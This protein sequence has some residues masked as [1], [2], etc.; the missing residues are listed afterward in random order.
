MIFEIIADR[1]NK[2]FRLILFLGLLFLIGFLA[3][4]LYIKAYHVSYLMSPDGLLYSNIAENFLQGQGL[5]NT[6]RADRVYVVGPVYPLILASVYKIFGLSNYAAVVMAQAILGAIS[7]VLAFK[8]GALLFGRSYGWVSFAL[9]LLYPLFPF[10][11]MY[12]LTE[13]TYV[14]FVTLFIYLMAFYSVGCLN[15]GQRTKSA[16]AIG[17]V[18]GIANLVRPLLMTVFPVILFWFWFIAGYKFKSAIKDFF[19][20]FF[21]CILVMSPWWIRNYYNYEKF[22]P[23]TNYGAFEFYAGNN[24]Y[25][26]TNEY[27]NSY[28]ITYDPKIKSMVEK[29]PVFRREEEY[30]RLAKTYILRYPL[31]FIQRTF[32]K[33]INLFWRP[34]SGWE[35]SYYKMPGYSLDRW[36]LLMGLAGGIISLIKF[37]KYGFLLLIAVYYGSVVSILTVV[38]AARYRI[39]IMPA[40]I[41]LA[42]LAIMEA[43]KKPIAMVLNPNF[44]IKKRYFANK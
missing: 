23:V 36:F 35:G 38:D 24:P 37:R 6:V 42:T 44:F 31:Q 33:E 5:N 12:V 32:Q 26:V 18:L 9:T 20:V 14:F 25:T 34:V 2:R 7:A 1:L 19:I 41:L 16:I 22:I 43:I 3:R 28:L 39:P 13:T 30:A 17:A 27:F 10:W 15:A 29:L 21:S 4:I 11:G 40:V 8:T